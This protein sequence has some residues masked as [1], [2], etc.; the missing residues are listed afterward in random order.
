MT[1]FSPGLLNVVSGGTDLSRVLQSLM[2]FQSSGTPL[3][4]LW[5]DMRLSR[6]LATTAARRGVFNPSMPRPISSR[7]QWN[8]MQT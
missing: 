5:H 6:V 8:R 1:I 7:W 4:Y 3:F 2:C